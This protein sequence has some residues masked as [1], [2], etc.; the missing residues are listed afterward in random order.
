MEK[1]VAVWFKGFLAHYKISGGR[2]G[3]FTAELLKY[4][5]AIET[6]PPNEFPLHKE[7]RHWID[8]DTNQDLL[9]ELGKAIEIQVYGAEQISNPRRRS[10][11]GMGDHGRPR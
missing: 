1:T 4:N 8:D 7:G 6:S 3:V 2:D 5:G 10:D 9:D 11:H